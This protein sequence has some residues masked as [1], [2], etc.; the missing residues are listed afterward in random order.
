[1]SATTISGP[2]PP[3]WGLLASKHDVEVNTLKDTY[4]LDFGG[5]STVVSELPMFRRSRLLAAVDK[6]IRDRGSSSSRQQLLPPQQLLLPPQQQQH[7]PAPWQQHPS[8]MSQYPSQQQQPPSWQHPSQQ[9]QPPSWQHPSQQPSYQ[10]WPPLTAASAPLPTTTAIIHAAPP[11]LFEEGALHVP[12]PPTPPWQQQPPPVSQYPSQQQQP[13]SWQHPSQQPSYQ[14][15]PT[16]TAASEPLPTA[17]AANHAAPPA[18][19]L[20][21]EPGALPNPCPPIT[22]CTLGA[23]QT[24]AKYTSY[25]DM[26]PECYWDLLAH[27]WKLGHETT[28]VL[29]EAFIPI[30]AV[31]AAALAS[32]PHEAS[33]VAAVFVA[34]MVALVDACLFVIALEESCK[35]Q[36]KRPPHLVPAIGGCFPLVRDGGPNRLRYLNVGDAIIGT[37]CKSGC[38]GRQLRESVSEQKRDMRSHKDSSAAEVAPVAVQPV[39]DESDVPLKER[40]QR[41]H[42]RRSEESREEPRRSEESREEPQEGGQKKKP[43]RAKTFVPLPPSIC[44][45]EGRKADTGNEALILREALTVFKEAVVSTVTE[46]NSNFFSLSA[47]DVLA[48]LTDAAH[49]GVG[50]EEDGFAACVLVTGLFVSKYLCAAASPS[51][52]LGVFLS[53]AADRTAANPEADG[54]RLASAA[55]MGRCTLRPCNRSM[56]LTTTSRVWPRGTRKDT[57]RIC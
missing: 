10:P 16:L 40:Q 14:P 48:A 13:P 43:A 54:S 42:A 50:Q 1:V 19:Q 53:L 39:P 47:E 18:L 32:V 36:G 49:S 22:T 6:F 20:T 17:T 7:P 24:I 29:D 38:L 56:R 26:L 34:Y 25:K 46:L 55:R 31:C 5:G 30:F 23:V 15:R 12:H 45:V 27:E 21:V 37:Q 2:R 51:H 52:D 4:R 11:A 3:A 28:S 57:T 33:R 44:T 41:L 35:S 8:P 9:Q